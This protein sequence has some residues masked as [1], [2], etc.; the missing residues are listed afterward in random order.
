M[1]PAIIGALIAAGATVGTTI[2]NKVSA[3]GPNA[4]QPTPE[5]M[6]K[7]AV[8]AEEA[9]RSVAT[10]QAAQFLPQLQSDTSGGLSPDAYR[11]LAANFSGNANL[12]NSPQMQQ[13]IAKFLGLDTGATFGGNEPFGSS[14]SSSSGGSSPFSTG[15]AG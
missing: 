11:S 10:K 9:N 12:S 6:T 1:P 14:N 5:E 8:S 2:Y 3:P 15:L 4:G 7:Q 13:L